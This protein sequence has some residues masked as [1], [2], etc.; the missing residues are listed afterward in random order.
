MGVFLWNKALLRQNPPEAKLSKN[1][2]GLQWHMAIL[3]LLKGI[4]AGN[5]DYKG[6]GSIKNINVSSQL[7]AAVIKTES[8]LSAYNGELL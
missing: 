3:D 4:Q 8:S 5:G 1:K 7:H 2:K 6:K